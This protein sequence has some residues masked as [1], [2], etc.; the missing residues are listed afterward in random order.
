ME[1]IIEE[2]SQRGE[3]S[4]KTEN[5]PQ[6]DTTS[7][8]NEEQNLDSDNELTKKIKNILDKQFKDIENKYTSAITELQDKTKEVEQEKYKIQLEKLLGDSKILDGRYYDFVYSND[9]E[10]VKTKIKNLENLINEKVR[11]MA[12]KEVDKRLGASVWIPGNNSDT[13]GIDNFSKQ[14]YML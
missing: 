6:K 14:P 8:N 11:E 10:L 1:D 7:R 9:I 12:Q 4:N 5:T 3:P 13:P 2:G